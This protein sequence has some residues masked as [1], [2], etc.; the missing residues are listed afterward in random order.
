MVTYNVSDS[1]IDSTLTSSN[2]PK[3]VGWGVDFVV[4]TQ[5]AF[6]VISKKGLIGLRRSMHSVDIASLTAWQNPSAAEVQIA[7]PHF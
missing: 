4:E 3:H 5:R 6:F 2:V 1:T 7:R